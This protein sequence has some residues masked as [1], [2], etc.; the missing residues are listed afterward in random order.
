MFAQAQTSLTDRLRQHVDFLAADSL[1][2]RK[3]GTADS[4][5]AADYIIEQW[6]AI[7]IK[8]FFETENGNG[9]LQEFRCKYTNVLGIIEGSDPALKDEYIV[10]G[11]HYDHLGVKLKNGD[12]VVYNG[13]DDNASGTATLIELARE[14]QSARLG[15]SIIFAA[16]DAEELGLF[17]SAFL[18]ADNGNRRIVLMLSID[19][20]GRYATTGKV[21]YEGVGTISNGRAMLLA[22]VPEGLKVKLKNFENSIFTATD[23]DGF[24]RLGIP[25]L[26]VTTGLHRQYHKPTDDIDLID[27]DGMTLIAE[28]LKSF[29]IAAAQAGDYQA[30]GKVAAKHLGLRPVFTKG[31]TVN[32]GRNHH[33]Y[34]AGAL[35]GKSAM[36]FGLGLTSQLNFGPGRRLAFRPELLYDFLQAQHPDGDIKAQCFTAPLNLVLQMKS[37]TPCFDVFF[38]GYY[39]HVFCKTLHRNYFPNEGGLSAGFD[40]GVGPIRIGYV[41]RRA[42]TDFAREDVPALPLE[43][44]VTTNIRNS[45][46]YFNIAYSF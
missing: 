29:I 35:D 26:A 45:S 14:L 24:A 43:S 15:R 39:R 34:T 16:F 40:M 8:P 18:A 2:G 25:T 21:E 4:R 12:S 20:V 5:K 6:K 17:G 32:I 9:Y 44:D 1:R 22:N 19:M 41:F 23:T 10:L 33:S 37:S 11:A 42:L 36:S 27:F 31:L 28:H 46:S 30:S 3:A 13:A 38:G 7:G